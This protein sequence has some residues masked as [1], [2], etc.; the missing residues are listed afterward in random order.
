MSFFFFPSIVKKS[1]CASGTGTLERPATRFK[2][3]ME[4]YEDLRVRSLLSL[5]SQ[6]ACSLSGMLLIAHGC[7]VSIVTSGEDGDGRWHAVDTIQICLHLA[8]IAPFVLI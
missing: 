3:W 6:K 2:A 4:S 7:W 1:S 8:V 5:G